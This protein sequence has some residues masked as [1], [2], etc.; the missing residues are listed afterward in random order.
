MK[1]NFDIKDNHAL[2]IAGRH[3]DLHNNFDFVGF[4]YN[5][6]DR[7]IKLHW[8]KSNGDWVDE[9]EF[10]SLVLTHIGVTYLKV[11]EQDEKSV[12]DDD[13]CLGEITFFPSTSR[14]VNDSIVSQPKPNDGDDVLYFFENGQ[15]IR[16]NCEQ[17]ELSVNVDKSLNL[18]ISNDEALV[19]LD[20]LARFNETEHS[21]IFEDKAEQQTLW[22]LERQL[23]KQLVEPFKPDYKDIIKVARNKISNEE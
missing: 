1:V 13:C 10:S 2:E 19:L 17:I 7:E 23:E 15:L 5:V 20:F 22:V 4:D 8:K 18:T 11:I 14:E 12:Y 21:D 3:I 9:N 16:I 6:V